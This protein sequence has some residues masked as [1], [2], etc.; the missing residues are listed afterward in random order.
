MVPVSASEMSISVLSI[1]MHAV[2]FLQA[3][4][5]RFSECRRVGRGEC[6]LGRGPKPRHRRPEVVADVVEGAAHA[7]DDGVDAIEHRVDE[8]A[9][10]AE[11]IGRVRSGNARDRCGR[12]A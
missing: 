7:G 12:S 4:G 11:R 6:T 10:F 3:V 9:Q 8:R 5:E 1:A 2:G